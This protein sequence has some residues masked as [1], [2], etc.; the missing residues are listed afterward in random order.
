LVHH[1]EVGN[2]PPEGISDISTFSEEMLRKYVQTAKPDLITYDMYYFRENRQSQEVGGTVIPFYDDLNRYRKIA[3]EGVDGTGL[4][5]IPFGNYMQAWRTGPGA[6]TP[7]KRG[8]GWYEM[9][10]SQIYLS[11]FANW[12]FGAKW[13]SIFRWIKDA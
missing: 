7:E 10:E 12:T 2:T 5:P 13:L 3:A 4:S 9:T 1:N 6:A 8:D 11:G